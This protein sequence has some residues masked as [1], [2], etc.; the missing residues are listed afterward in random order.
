MWSVISKIP[1]MITI[2]SLKSLIICLHGFIACTD[3]IEL[4]T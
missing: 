1:K 3:L 2:K 4:L